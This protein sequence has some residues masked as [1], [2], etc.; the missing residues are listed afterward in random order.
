MRKIVF[1][2]IAWMKYYKDVFGDQ[3]RNGG[4]FIDENGEGCEVWNFLPYNHKCYGYVMHYG[5]ELH[6]ENY[7]EKYRKKDEI[8]DMTVVWVASDGKG[9]KIVGWYEHATMYR[10][11]QLFQGRN[12]Y[13]FMADEKDCYLIEENERSFIIPRASKVGSGKGM[14]QSQIWYATDPEA[15]IE[16]VPKVLEYLDSMRDKCQPIYYNPQDLEK[17][18]EDHGQSIDEMFDRIG[19]VLDSDETYQLGCKEYEKVMLECLQLANLAVAIDDAADTRLM[20]GLVLN[21]MHLQEEAEEELK[22]SLHHDRNVAVLEK[23]MF[24]E[25]ALGHTFT[26]IELGE[27][28][29]SH[30]DEYEE[31]GY[32]AGYLLRLYLQEKEL[33]LAKQLLHEC[34]TD[35]N[36]NHVYEW[37]PIAQNEIAKIEK[38]QNI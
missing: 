23:L 27:E 15:Q 14:G 21:G 12:D 28:L 24:I 18:A 1:C 16:L 29:R 31:W 11:W 38:E 25:G 9:S 36:E 17:C 6:I 26:A 3:P 4:K 19:D 10:Y 5:N 32:D 8:D 2:E 33:E 30:K 34:E 20:K 37:L 7:G 13:N 35:S 22:K